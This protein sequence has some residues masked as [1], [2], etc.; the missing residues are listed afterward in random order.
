MCILTS[1]FNK[2]GAKVLCYVQIGY[3]PSGVKWI[4]IFFFKADLVGCLDM[5]S[6]ISPTV[7]DNKVVPTVCVRDEFTALSALIHSA[8]MIVGT[9]IF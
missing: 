6:Y 3:A 2:L 5:L 7:S 4:K 1:K 8:T 9:N